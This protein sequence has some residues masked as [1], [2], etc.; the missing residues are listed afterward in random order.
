MLTTLADTHHP[1][2]SPQ[3]GRFLGGIRGKASPG[4]SGKQRSPGDAPEG[5]SDY[6]SKLL[7]L[8]WHPEA[9][10]LA[11]AASNSLYMYAAP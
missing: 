11:C 6:G 9:N 5:G 8:A 4:L 1:A 2:H 7:H 3:G 10:V